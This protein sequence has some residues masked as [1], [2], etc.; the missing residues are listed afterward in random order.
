MKM[1]I[2]AS[3]SWLGG[4]VAMGAMGGGA[5]SSPQQASDS[6][7]ADAPTTMQLTSTG[8][9]EGKPIPP[10]YACTDHEHLGKSPP[11][12]WSRGPEGTA[13]Y[14]IT[15]TDPDAKNFVHWA[16]I[17]IPASTTS[18]PEGASPGGALPEGAAELPNDFG[19]RGYG[20]PCPPPGKPHHY[21]FRVTALKEQVRATKADAAF[22][23]ALERQALATGS[24]TVTF[25]R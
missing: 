10:Q 9:E 7:P 13:A 6:G 12:A 3:G 21:V 25:Q 1:A 14:A 19:K 2:V 20:G 22:L 24:I 18:L 5:C 17:N 15:V 11:L 8:L 4:V 23:R 16:L